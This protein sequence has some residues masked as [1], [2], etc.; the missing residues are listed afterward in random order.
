M[1]RETVL[2]VPVALLPEGWTRDV[3]IVISPDGTIASV[4]VAVPRADATALAGPVLP[5]MTDL[6]S[7]AFQY[8]MAGLAET[9]SPSGE[10]HF[11]SWRETM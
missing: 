5:G 2:H 1:P 6:H 11:W 3:T 9:R 10:D 8:A 4:A 7:H